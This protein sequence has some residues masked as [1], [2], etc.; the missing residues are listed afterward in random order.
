MPEYF[1]RHG[2]KCPTD[3]RHGPFQYAFNTDQA[4]FEYIHSDP[5]RTR[6]FNTY[7]RIT[8]TFRRHWT[9]Y[10]PVEEALLEDYRRNKKDGNG[11]G[12]ILLVDIGGG[13]GHD[14]QRFAEKFPQAVDHNKN[15]G[16]NLVLQDLPRTIGAL[17]PSQLHKAIRPM[18][19]D[20]FTPQP[21]KGTPLSIQSS[22]QIHTSNSAVQY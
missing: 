17:E 9:E 16:R 22:P 3:G 6:N 19:H 1:Q 15:G 2:Y 18:V 7:M 5:E 11:D 8:R 10:F 14:L 21:I 20:M 4:M 13:S 12:E